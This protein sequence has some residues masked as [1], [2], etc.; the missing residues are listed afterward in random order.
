VLKFCVTTYQFCT[1][2]SRG[3]QPYKKLES[4]WKHNFVYS[5]LENVV[6]VLSNYESIKNKVQPV[7]SEMIKY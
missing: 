1:E 6:L 3:Q 7:L 4:I 5:G 2:V